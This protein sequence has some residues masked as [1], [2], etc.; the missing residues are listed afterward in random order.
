MSWGQN[1]LRDYQVYER[2]V[3]S[4]G[5]MV[6]DSCTTQASFEDCEQGRG[7]EALPRLLSF[8]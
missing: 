8:E 3:Q 7:L 2:S 5:G 4:V 6:E 1:S